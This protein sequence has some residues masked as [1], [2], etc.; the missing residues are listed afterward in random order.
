MREIHRH[1][2]QE[3]VRMNVCTP[4]GA[5]ENMYEDRDELHVDF[6]EVSRHM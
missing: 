6:T 5:G 3:N 1:K 4:P 2:F